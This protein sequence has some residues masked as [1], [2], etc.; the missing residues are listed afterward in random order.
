MIN[1]KELFTI[2]NFLS[3]SRLLLGIPVC[4]LLDGVD[5][6]YSRRL[7]LLFVLMIAAATDYLDGYFA[8]KNNQITEAGKII[9]PLADKALVAILAVKLYLI[10]ELPPFYF[11]A[12][13][14]R[15]ILI[16][17]GGIVVT[18]IIGKVL[19]SNLL[20]KITVTVIG[21]FFIAVILQLKIYV[22]FLYNVLYY[23]GLVLI[24]SSLIA[25]IIR[26]KESITWYK[27]ESIQEH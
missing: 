16:F 25:Y 18:R 12:I 8:R 14:S 3:F 23:T 5:Q 24:F 7:I 21:F 9:D 11:Y 13:I 6:S 2:S 27:N 22:P 4:L 17:V 20:G 1:R 26:A 15:D 19:P 10:G